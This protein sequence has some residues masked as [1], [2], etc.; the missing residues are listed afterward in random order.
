MI[1]R[2]K[3]SLPGMALVALVILIGWPQAQKWWYEQKP[4]L[5]KTTPLPKR[6]NTATQPEYKSMDNKNQPYTITADH[7]EETSIEDIQLMHP[8]MVMKLNSGEIVTLTS[9]SGKLN[10]STN[11]MHLVGNVTLTHSQGYNLQTAQAWIDCNRGTA[12][13][14]TPVSGDGPA[15]AIQSHGFRM[16]DRGAKVSFVGGAQLLLTKEGK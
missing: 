8:K 16:T 10:K 9:T 4:A 3:Y 5:A 2:L 14:N 12:F 11:E 7:G 13:S 1:E 15:G 6:N